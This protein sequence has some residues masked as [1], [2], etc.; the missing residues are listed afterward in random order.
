MENVQILWESERFVVINKPAGMV[1]NRTESNKNYTVQDWIEG[2]YKN[3]M[4]LGRDGGEDEEVFN[5]RLGV[6][7]RLDKETSGCLIIAKDYQALRMIMD[8]FRSRRVEKEYLA[9]VHGLVDPKEGVIKLPIKRSKHDRKRQEIRFDGKKAETKWSVE[10]EFSGAALTNWTGF[11]PWGNS[12]SLVRLKPKTGRM[13]QIRVHLAHLGHP[14]FSDDKYLSDKQKEEDRK[15]L[16]HHFLHA[17][18]I[19]FLDESG[20][21]IEVVSRLNSDEEKLLLMLE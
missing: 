19:R 7:H 15:V 1:V 4:F 3:E 13:H 17:E 21:N 16:S 18:K 6:A 11:L 5:H 20:K 8:Q 12:L 10:A 2:Y 14:I 9:L